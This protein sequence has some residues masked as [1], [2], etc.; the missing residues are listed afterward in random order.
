MAAFV[1]VLHA[2]IARSLLGAVAVGVPV[3]F[4]A[5]PFTDGV[6]G[7]AAG[8]VWWVFFGAVP[9]LMLSF[10]VLYLWSALMVLLDGIDR[11]G[12]VC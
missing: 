8:S 11:L 7:R 4:L 3:A 6:L 12:A 5:T 10:G 2:W 1:L 9:T